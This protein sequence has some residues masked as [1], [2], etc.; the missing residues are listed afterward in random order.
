MNVDNKENN[1]EIMGNNKL[2]KKLYTLSIKFFLWY[3]RYKLDTILFYIKICKRFYL[4]SLCKHL[5]ACKKGNDVSFKQLI[6]KK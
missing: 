2:Y 4:Y 5:K 6:S 3:N 1:K